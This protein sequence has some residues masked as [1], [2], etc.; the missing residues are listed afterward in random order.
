MTISVKFFFLCSF[1]ITALWPV[2]VI[3]ETNEALE[4]VARFSLDADTPYRTGA[5]VRV[6]FTL[7]NLTDADLWILEWNTP[8]EGILNRIFDITCD[9]TEAPYEGRMVKRGRPAPNDYLKLG[10]YE[11]QIRTV[12]LSSVYNF[13]G[14]EECLVTFRGTLLDI[15][16][17]DPN[18][19]RSSAYELHPV[20]IH[21]ND[22]IIRIISNGNSP[23][24]R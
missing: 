14:I 12:E 19:R 17:M 15:S 22:V 9:G 13:S 10:P 4:A 24:F 16:Q 6:A 5:P 23:A 2:A 8:F 3:P 20:E 21:G 7:E 11:K 1:C 18:L